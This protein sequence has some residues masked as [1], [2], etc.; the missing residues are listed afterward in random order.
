MSI[1]PWMDSGEPEVADAR[2]EGTE[3]GEPPHDARIVCLG[4][5]LVDF[6]CERPVSSL[7]EADFFVPR[8]GGSL[9]NIAIAASIFSDHV[10]LIGGVGDDEW[11]RWLHERIDGAG[12]DTSRFDLLPG[13]Q[14]SHA[15]VSVD[16]KGEPEFAFY[17]DKVR[18]SAHA[19]THLETA[20]SGEEGVLV[21]G[22]DS[23]LGGDERE[24][25]MQAVAL[26][27][28]Q[29]WAILCDPN[30]RPNRW[31]SRREMVEVISSLVSCAD[32]V[33]LNESEALALSGMMSAEAAG[34][35]LLGLGPRAVVVTRGSHGAVVQT[36][37]SVTPIK[38]VAAK[39]V[40]STG[41]GDS[42]CGVL[43]AGMARWLPLDDV[44]TAAMYVAAGVVGVW[45]ATEGLP[46]RAEA[47]RLL[48][49]G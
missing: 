44:V 10:E 36:P 35:W 29:R 9:A 28:E 31:G 26:A 14:T 15:F 16:D 6:V 17:G 43:A 22:S 32:V 45:G 46:T 8:Q 3:A 37:R 7:V 19:G 38:G 18:P 33:K 48:Q 27:Q 12:V 13:V 21:V 11:G 25:T 30:L 1:L 5:A 40:D 24:V 49:A 39:V 41:A 34:E 20:I 23:L 4:E 2:P 42:V 47:R